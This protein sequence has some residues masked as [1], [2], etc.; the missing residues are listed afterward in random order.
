MVQNLQKLW[1]FCTLRPTCPRLSFALISWERLHQGTSIS[2]WLLSHNIS[3]YEV[4]NYQPRST[5]T[6]AKLLMS[7]IRS[8]CGRDAVLQ[9]MRTEADGPEIPQV[10][11]G[12]WNGW[13]PEVG[14]SADGTQGFRESKR[15][16]E[17]VLIHT[18]RRNRRWHSGSRV[19]KRQVN[20]CP[21]QTNQQSKKQKKHVPLASPVHCQ[22]QLFAS[23]F[24]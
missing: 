5:Q 14:A 2:G 9:A 4:T 7:Q 3:T 16:W 21:F 15:G 6:V 19:K 12:P 18:T 11:L 24:D 13:A 23:C 22:K 10:R 17:I 20:S 1:A 8:W